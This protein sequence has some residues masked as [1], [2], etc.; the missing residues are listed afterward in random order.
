[1]RQNGAAIT[2]KQ[3]AIPQDAD[4]GCCVAIVV[5]FC[6]CGG[7]SSG[8]EGKCT[9]RGWSETNRCSTQ[10]RKTHR[11][12]GLIWEAGRYARLFSNLTFSYNYPIKAFTFTYISSIISKNL[13]GSPVHYIRYL[14]IF[15]FL[16][17]H[18]SLPRDGWDCK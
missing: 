10:E 18:N 2:T 14:T 15:L 13:C 4:A 3:F 17:N 7:R 1:M 6:K 12:V 8:E 16:D 5:R 9:S 11:L